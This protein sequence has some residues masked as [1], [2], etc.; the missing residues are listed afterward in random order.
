M[1]QFFSLSAHSPCPLASTAAGKALG[2]SP[3][4]PP[5]F[6]GMDIANTVCQAE[7]MPLPLLKSFASYRGGGKVA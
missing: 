7:G 6:P 2:F 5:D 4:M 1:H 3:L